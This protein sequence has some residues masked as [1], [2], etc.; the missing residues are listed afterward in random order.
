M[1]ESRLFQICIN[2]NVIVHDNLVLQAYFNL[3][4]V[5]NQIFSRISFFNN[6][7]C[8]VHTNKSHNAQRNRKD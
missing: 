4:T 6:G 3:K 2:K 1:T 7:Q 5:K 8:Y